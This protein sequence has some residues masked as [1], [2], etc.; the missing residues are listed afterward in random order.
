[1]VDKFI[2]ELEVQLSERSVTIELTDEARAWLAKKGYDRN[3]GARPLGRV[4]QEHIKR[5]LSEE[6]LFGKLTDGGVALVT[7]DEDNRLA[8]AYPEAA[9]AP[10]KRP[11]APSAKGGSKDS[12]GKKAGGKGVPATAKRSSVPVV[13]K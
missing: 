8:F 10:L 1:V 13:V 4:I 3:F 6:L 9:P 7:V 2:M 11:K 5:P 12:K